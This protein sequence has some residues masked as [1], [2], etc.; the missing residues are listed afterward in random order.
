MAL[1]EE[2]WQ[3]LI[4]NFEFPGIHDIV[5]LQS[6]FLERRVLFASLVDLEVRKTLQIF[7]DVVN[8]SFL[9]ELSLAEDA[10]HLAENIRSVV[11]SVKK[12][13]IRDL[14]IQLKTCYENILTF[15]SWT[16]WP[17][18]S[19]IPC[20]FFSAVESLHWSKPLISS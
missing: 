18:M 17:L 2:L 15:R 6:E 13:M 7:I 10:G 1:F 5:L 20:S 3:E 12:R 19:R 8:V 4:K 9:L 16:K 11:T 14:K